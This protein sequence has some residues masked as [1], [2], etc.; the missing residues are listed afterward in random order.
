MFCLVDNDPYGIGIYGV[1]KY[2]SENASSVERQ[3]L[4]LPELQYLGV[5]SSDFADGEGLIELTV[6]DKRKIELMLEKEWVK[7]D[8][9]I[10]YT[11][12][13]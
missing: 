13:L 11:L 1:Y 8:P 6:R 7:E 2:G 4:A 3:R 9:I 10:R 12:L 5:K